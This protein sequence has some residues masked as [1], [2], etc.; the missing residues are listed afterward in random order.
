M[1][2]IYRTVTAVLA[3]AFVLSAVTASAA[4]ASPEWLAKTGGTFNKL[5]SALND[6]AAGSITINDS[7]WLGGLKVTCAI[8]ISKGTIEA[9]GIGKINEYTLTGCEPA[10]GGACESVARIRPIHMPWKTELYREGTQI[11]VRIVSGGSGTPEWAI[12]CNTSLGE[13]T[14]VCGLN[15]SAKIQNEPPNV[16]AKFDGESNKTVCG[17]KLTG[18]V[19]GELSFAPPA[20]TEAVE[21]ADVTAGEWL[22]AGVKLSEAV[23]TRSKGTLKLGDEGRNT[24]VEC[25]YTGEGTAGPFAADKETSWT[26]TKCTTI[27]A[28]ACLGAIEVKATNL[29][30]QSELTDYSG[31]PY[32]LVSSGGKGN[33]G[34][35][36][37]CQTVIGKQVDTCDAATISTEIKDVTGGVDSTFAG[38]QL[39]CHG[40]PSASKAR[41][42]GTRLIESKTGGT[43]EAK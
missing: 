16:V 34:Y 38:Q 15:T 36:L 35:S 40:V 2:S 33:V 8:K 32:D 13:R 10:A 9:G 43:L 24:S 37:T 42:E 39:E 23:A 11:R 27:K 30:W 28:G 6:E 1:R 17:E 5:T 29:P 22:Q 26:A 4:L 3:V 20:G 31:A 7:G 21:V 41:P 25:E 18:Q 14:D 12:D 19:E